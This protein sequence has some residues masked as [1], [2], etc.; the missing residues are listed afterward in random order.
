MFWLIIIAVL[1][2]V[3]GTFAFHGNDFDTISPPCVVIAILLCL[4]MLP[5]SGVITYPELLAEKESA[6]SLKE[7]IQDVRNSYYTEQK[8]SS[9]L[10]DGS[11]TNI[12]QSTILSE[13][14]RAYARKK[15]SFNQRLKWVQE[16]KKMAFFHIF[17][18]ATFVSKEVF[19]IKR[20]EG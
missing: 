16:T 11:L 13:Y 18:S 8:G 3:A 7:N 10:I 5:V 9:V 17:G 6:L 19:N 12:K 14:I 4:A 15:A 2:L 20:I 1:I